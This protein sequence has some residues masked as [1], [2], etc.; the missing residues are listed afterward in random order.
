[1][2][3]LVLAALVGVVGAGWYFSEKN[4]QLPAAP[5][6]SVPA[7]GTVSTSAGPYNP[8]GTSPNGSSGLAAIGMAGLGLNA[9]STIGNDVSQNFSASGV[10][11][12]LPIVGAGLAVV[13]AVW[14]A[15]SAHHKEAVAKEA[16]GLNQA[17]PHFFQ[18]C[19]LIMQAA[20]QKQ[21]TPQQISAALDEAESDYYT[22]CS[23]I[24]QG[25]W[26]WP[27][28]G[29]GN[30]QAAPARPG[31]CNGPCVVGHFWVATGVAETK[32]RALDALK[33]GHGKM[34]LGP[35]PPHAGFNGSPAV[36]V[37]Y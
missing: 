22:M 35:C 37:T 2:P 15:I 7:P 24:I 20:I 14:S 16:A 8:Y 26:D 31:T 18:A 25:K 3:L 23:G 30:L 13:G 11:S 10:G 4:G 27:S 5:S 17:V 29:Q 6:Q 1:M 19:V 34:Q 32:K 36:Y 33:G 28:D 12:A 9:A 21:A